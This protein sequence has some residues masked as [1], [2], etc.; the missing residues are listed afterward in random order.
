M[1]QA[2]RSA[3]SAGVPF[4]ARQLTS[5][6]FDDDRGAGDPAVLAALAGSTDE[7]ALLD[8]VA[9]ARWLVPV[10]ATAAEVVDG[11]HGHAVDA[12]VDMAVVTLVGPQGDR[13][14]P[15]FSSLTTLAAWDRA[16]RPVPVTA[17]RAAQAAVA[18]G[19]HALLL[20]IGAPHART[21]RPSM[22]WAL[23]QQ[24]PWLPAHEDP[25]VAT[26][27]G[28]AVR[29]RPEVTAYALSAGT[30]HGEGVLAITLTLVPGLAPEE[31]R[32]LV[33]GIGEQLAGDGEFRARADAL[34]FVI[35]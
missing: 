26:S 29:G 7:A 17:A 33:T 34:A 2:D 20:D 6:G 4:H 11:A 14:L 10:V 35:R 31:V 28:R 16:A 19:C 15:V 21:L 22:L 24:R 27:V 9:A 18:E 13:A 30:P 3:D 5:T 23:A 25:F 12:Q 1:S 32:D 8:A